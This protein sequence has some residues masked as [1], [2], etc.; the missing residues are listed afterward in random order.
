LGTELFSH[1]KDPRT[2]VL[3][4]RAL[5]HREG[6]SGLASGITLIR[7]LLAEYWDSLHP[8][9]DTDEN[10]DPTERMNALLDLCNWDALLT[11]AR[12]VPLV[13]SRSF[14]PG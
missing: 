6:F 11:P 5:L 9:L 1:R 8:Q 2:A 7:R 4:S 3:I 10:N 14:G 13:H 12:T